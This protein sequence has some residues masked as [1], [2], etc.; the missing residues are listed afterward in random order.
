MTEIQVGPRAAMQNRN[1]VEIS[2]KSGLQVLF[3]P[4]E[5]LQTVSINCWFQS[6]SLHEKKGQAGLAHF[7]EHMLFTASTDKTN[8]EMMRALQEVGGY[9][10][11]FT[12]YDHTGYECVVPIEY[13]AQGFEW[14]RDVLLQPV[15]D[16]EQIAKEK[17]VI[18]SEYTDGQDQP[19]I[20]FEEKFWD[21]IY[22]GKTLGRPIL[23][24]P[25]DIQNVTADNL[26]NFYQ[27][28][29]HPSRMTLSVCGNVSVEDI[30]KNLST[31]VYPF[32][33]KQ[34]PDPKDIDA[35]EFSPISFAYQAGTEQ[36]KL[37][38]LFES[39]GSL[40]QDVAAL[41]LLSAC[42]GGGEYAYLFKTLRQEKQW[43]SHAHAHLF[44]TQAGGHFGLE[45]IP[46][47]KYMQDVQ[48]F[49]A[50]MLS[51]PLS[52]D[53]KIIAWAKKDIEK[54]IIYSQDTTWGRSK[55]NVYFNTLFD[56]VNVQH[57]YYEQLQKINQDDLQRVYQNYL[58][59][60]YAFGLWK[61][62]GDA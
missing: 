46:F 47:E 2:H 43:V 19:E 42:L 18:L 62:Q 24:L 37:E 11:A 17:G 8:V 44:I 9:A 60:P 23:G 6:G 57:T 32:L 15:F 14:V 22:Q 12:T 51:K 27:E 7:L 56:D 34:P 4:M 61:A 25:Q 48:D 50:Q 29:Y 36:R 35:L 30:K 40:H 28:N 53:S 1:I 39:V 33:Q 16:Q 10:N 49:I 21:Q 26:Q 5:H 58:Q 45:L 20:V 13:M 55:L 41:E 52:L 3:E 59:K 54:E 38:Y 31:F